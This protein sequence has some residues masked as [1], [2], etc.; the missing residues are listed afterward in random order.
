MK[1]W[2]DGNARPLSQLDSAAPLTDL[3]PM[4][5]MIGD[6]VVVGLGESTRASRELFVTRLRIFRLLVERLGFR[7]LAIQDNEVISARLDKYVRTAEGDPRRLLTEAWAPWRTEETVEA[8]EWIRS[9]NARHPDDPVR[10]LGV[11]PPTAQL[12]HYDAVAAYV[13]QVAPERLDD[14]ETHYS[15]IRTAHDVGEH[16]QRF[17]GTHPGRPFVEHAR[18]ALTLVASLPGGGGWDEALRYT[19]TIIEFHDASIAGNV[20]FNAHARF[21]ADAI[22]RWH[23]DSGA[24][25]AYWDGVPFVAAGGPFDVKISSGQQVDG[26]GGRLRR[27]LGERYL[28]VLLGFR[29]GRIHDHVKVPVPPPDYV[30]ATLSEAD[31]HAYYVD[32]RA[33][34]PPEVSEWLAGARKIRVVPGVYDPAEDA[35]HHIVADSLSG[36]FDVVVYIREI[37]PTRPLG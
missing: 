29:N 16:I 28:A 13:R 33:P 22:A 18:D 9:H 21:A 15:P 20:D 3:E 26:P 25:V 6:A 27:H 14:L 35:E 36:W 32:L 5:A 11:S 2:I 34:S 12:F 31:L 30:E 1:Q 10:I 24:K 17:R 4:A 23:R 37:T 7:A 8:L 19:R